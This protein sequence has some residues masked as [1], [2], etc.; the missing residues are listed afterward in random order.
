MARYELQM[1]VYAA[2]PAD[3]TNVQNA[4]AAGMV[5]RAADIDQASDRVNRQQIDNDGTPCLMVSM[6]GTSRAGIDRVASF[7][8]G[9][10]A[11]RNA[12]AGG[13][14]WV[15]EVD[16]SGVVVDTVDLTV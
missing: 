5:S 14:S 2:T 6:A 3:L 8:T 12:H 15:K 11:S 9:A 16:D 13:V 4:V 1:M 7:L 10:L